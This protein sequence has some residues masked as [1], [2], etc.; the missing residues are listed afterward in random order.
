MKSNLGNGCTKIKLVFYIGNFFILFSYY[1]EK[2]LREF[3][4][5]KTLILK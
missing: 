4:G 5:E 2:L 3:E 1:F